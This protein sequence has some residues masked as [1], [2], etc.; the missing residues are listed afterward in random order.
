M[1]LA[2]TGDLPRQRSGKLRSWH[3]RARCADGNGQHLFFAPDGELKGPRVRRER[4]AKR[5][6]G[7]CTVIVECRRYALSA[8]EL[9]GVWGGTSELDRKLLVRQ[10]TNPTGADG[11]STSCA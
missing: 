4:E 10:R 1:T 9:H 2:A 6:C 5:I 7:H 3:P 8:D 11:R